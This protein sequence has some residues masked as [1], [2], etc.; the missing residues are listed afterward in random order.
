[1]DIKYFSPRWGYDDEDFSS[2]CVR[3]AE[4]GFDGMELNLAEDPAAAERQI[5]TLSAHGLDYIAQHSGTRMPDF[6]THRTHYRASLERIAAF[7]PRLI[8]AHTGRDWFAD[9]QNLQLIDIAAEISE[10]SNVPVVHETHR[11]RFSFSAALTFR[12]LK[13]RPG[14][15]LASDFSHWCCVSE[16]FLQDQEE[17]VQAA[18]ERTDL[19]HARIGHDQGPQVNDPRAPEWKDALDLYLGWWDRVVACHEETGS[20]VLMITTEFGP[21]PYTPV[22]AYTQEPVSSQWELNLYMLRCLKA[23]FTQ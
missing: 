13:K 10:T 2:Y 21:P 3:L 1:M 18:I 12:Y 17:A 5:E 6:E 22:A 15:R 9:E 11:G 23:R 16:S 14:L 20:A 19:I 7:K 4:A 8:N